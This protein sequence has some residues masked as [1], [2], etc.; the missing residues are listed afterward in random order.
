MDS[1]TFLSNIRDLIARDELAAALTQLRSLLD[2]SPKL[3]EALLQSA[4]F[5]DIRKQIRLG[6][7]SHAEANLTQNQIRAGLLDLLREIE[8]SVRVTSSH[9]DTKAFR[10]EIERAISIVNSKNLVVGSTISAGGNVEIGDRTIH[11]ESET[12]R[13]LW[14]FLLLFVPVL[15]IGGTFFWVRYQQMREPLSLNVALDNRTPNLELPFESGT[16]TLQ[17]GDE[18]KTLSIQT[19]ADFKG[20][21]ANFRDETIELRFVAPGFVKIDTAFVLSGK[22]ISLPIYR[23]N[24]LGRVF[25]TVKDEQGNPLAGVQIRVQDLSVTT[26]ASGVFSLT[27]PFAKQRKE[28]RIEAFLQGFDLWDNTSPVLENEEI[29]IILQSK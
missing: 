26:N 16:V 11:T 10:E 7:V 9:P 1:K 12:K 4:R 14:L 8:E 29:P 23:D 3:D 27:I 20:I 22:R 17:Y 13:R 25:G 24:S 28:Q 21:P 5:Q 19:E 2:N 6:T 18:S 15:A